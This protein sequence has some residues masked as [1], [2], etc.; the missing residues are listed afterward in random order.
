[1]SS[2]LRIEIHEP[3]H[4]GTG[5]GAGIGADALTVKDAARL[6]V[7]PGRQVK[8]LLRDAMRRAEAAGTVAKGRTV[9]L[10]GTPPAP[11]IDGEGSLAS[12]QETERYQTVPGLLRIGSG[13][14]GESEDDQFGW[15]QWAAG[16][17]DEAAELVGEM[18]DEITSTAIED[19]TVKVGALRTVEV[20]MPVTLHA[21]I[22]SA[23]DA[24]WKEDVE[25]SLGLLRAI[26]KTR[27]R[28]FGRCTVTLLEEG[29]RR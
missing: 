29:G 13:C 26:G 12:W 4:V 8:G 5:T 22:E 10:F 11:R 23:G 19:G 14:L 17:G 9:E 18:Y 21:P 3:W 15:R 16:G 7:L 24:S 27:H 25:A 2:W 20:A 6:P 1:M 28:G